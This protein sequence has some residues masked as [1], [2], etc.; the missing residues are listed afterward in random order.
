MTDTA[1][2]KAVLAELQWDPSISAAHIGVIA[3]DGVVALTGHVESYAEKLATEA[4]ARRVKGVKAIAQEIE[5]RLPFHS[6]RDDDE[7]AGA[8]KDRLAWDVS[9]PANAIIAEVEKG[10]ITLTGEVDWHYQKK[11]AEHDVFGLHGVR[12]VTNDIRIKSRVDVENI[13]D[14]IMHAMNRSWFFDPKTIDVTAQGGKVRLAGTVKS[15]HDK[16]LAAATA[17]TAPGVTDV[18]NDIVVS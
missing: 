10:W 18:E 15:I 17:W 1:L 5:V 11:A 13:S 16:Q 9:L 12:G 4:A 3:N 8:A 2:Q 6:K 14:D 7:I